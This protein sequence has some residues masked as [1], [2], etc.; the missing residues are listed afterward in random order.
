MLLSISR[1][2]ITGPCVLVIYLYMELSVSVHCFC[3]VMFKALYELLVMSCVQGKSRVS[4]SNH[5]AYT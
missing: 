3:T 2:Y 1:L 5:S 4:V